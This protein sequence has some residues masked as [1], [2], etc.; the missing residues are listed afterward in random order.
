MR[1]EEGLDTGD[2]AEERSTPIFGKSSDQ[3]YSELA[4]LGGAALV[5]VL[6][7]LE[8]GDLLAGVSNLKPVL[9]MLK[10]SRRASL[11]SLRLFQP[12]TRGAG[13]FRQVKAMHVA[14]LSRANPFPF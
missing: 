3:L 9:R 10:K 4:V 11:I 14:A 7:L 2:V 12:T 8:N 1:M 5:K 6:D 13:C